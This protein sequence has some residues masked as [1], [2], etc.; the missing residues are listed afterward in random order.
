MQYEKVDAAVKQVGLR[1]TCG[2]YVNYVMLKFNFYS[3]I[4]SFQALLLLRLYFITSDILCRTLTTA[5]LST[6]HVHIKRILAQQ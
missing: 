2:S 6:L 1:L 5:N 3:G 4:S